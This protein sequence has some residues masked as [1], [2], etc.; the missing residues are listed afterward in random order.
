[1]VSSLPY[2]ASHIK[3]FVH[4]HP[5]ASQKHFL[6]DNMNFDYCLQKKKK[7]TKTK[8]KHSTVINN[9]YFLV[10]DYLEP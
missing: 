6:I 4:G 5:H 10:L 1:M 8:T 2:M 7:K 3:S 9:F